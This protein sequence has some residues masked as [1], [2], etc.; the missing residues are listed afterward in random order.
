MLHSIVVFVHIRT[1]C[2]WSYA[3]IVEWAHSGSVGGG[4]VRSIIM[5][6]S[7]TKRIYATRKVN[8][9]MPIVYNT[10]HCRGMYGDWLGT[11]LGHE[12]TSTPWVIKN[13]SFYW[14]IVW[15]VQFCIQH[16]AYSNRFSN[17]KLPYMHRLELKCWKIRYI[18]GDAFVI[19]KH[20]DTYHV[21]HESY[22]VFPVFCMCRSSGKFSGECVITMVTMAIFSNYSRITKKLKPRFCRLKLNIRKG[23]NYHKYQII[24]VN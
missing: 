16:N 19:Y 24:E 2:V 6:G 20:T 4:L 23:L 21:E 7:Q 10:A 1:N 11:A 12:C 9:S 15:F 18:L 13:S 17:E 8:V 5:F 14:C 22:S 3:I